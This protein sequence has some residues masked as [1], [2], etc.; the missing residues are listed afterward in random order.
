MW[1]KAVATRQEPGFYHQSDEWK[2]KGV[3]AKNV[4][5]LAKTSRYR[6]LL[7]ASNCRKRKSS[8]R[9]HDSLAG[10]SSLHRIYP[11]KMRE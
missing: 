10:N 9:L 7:G 3:I 5:L 1:L 2:T 6:D 4:E 11:H 8:I